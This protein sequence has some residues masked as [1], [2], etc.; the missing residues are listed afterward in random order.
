METFYW[1]TLFLYFNI[2][3]LFMLVIILSAFQVMV[4]ERYYHQAKNQF[5]GEMYFEIVST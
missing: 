2:G 4:N 5:T 1:S 3:F